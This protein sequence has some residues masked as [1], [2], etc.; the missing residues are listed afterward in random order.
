MESANNIKKCKEE[1]NS[2]VI[3]SATDIITI[4]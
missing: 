1:K 4:L 3:L 2:P